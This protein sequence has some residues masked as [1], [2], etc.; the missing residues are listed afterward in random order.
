VCYQ[1]L[2]PAEWHPPQVRVAAF[3][4]ERVTSTIPSWW[5]AAFTV[6]APKS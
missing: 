4:L 1:F 3:Q 2:D 5:V 6:R